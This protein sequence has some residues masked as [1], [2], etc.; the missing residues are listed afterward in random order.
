[1]DTSTLLSILIGALLTWGFAHVYYKR[2]GD[3]LLNEAQDLRKLISML[4]TSLEQQ[5][6][7]KLNRDSAGNIIGF[8]YEHLSSG[9]IKFGGAAK[10]EFS[11]AKP[12]TGK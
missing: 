7:A 11:S 3:E 4:L 10:V 8:T 2:A 9:G 5:G 6:L 12:E 1:M